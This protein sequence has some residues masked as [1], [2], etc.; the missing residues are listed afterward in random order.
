V[1]CRF[2]W[3]PCS[4]APRPSF[5]PLALRKFSF[6][7]QTS[8][9]NFFYLT[10]ATSLINRAQPYLAAFFGA[11]LEILQKSSLAESPNSADAYL[12]VCALDLLAV[13][14]ANNGE[15]F[16]HLALN[17]SSSGNSSIF[18]LVE[19]CSSC[20][21]IRQSACVLFGAISKVL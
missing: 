6:F 20:A 8:S 2:S 11:S 17:F 3:R 12:N 16:W 7:L 21:Q 15:E 1:L 5:K 14:C 13:L 10:F 18:H 9:A 4:S 19:K